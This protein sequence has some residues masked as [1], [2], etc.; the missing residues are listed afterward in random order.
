LADSTDTVMK[1]IPKALEDLGNFFP[2]PEEWAVL[3][4]DKIL[5]KQAFQFH[6]KSFNRN[7]QMVRF[8]VRSRSES[9]IMDYAFDL[10]IETQIIGEAFV[11]P[12]CYCGFPFGN[13]NLLG[14]TGII[15]RLFPTTSHARWA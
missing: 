4:E 14:P 7:R 1:D 2:H 11:I 13:P 10:L 9:M 6:A 8:N 15:F 3:D 12:L 5:F